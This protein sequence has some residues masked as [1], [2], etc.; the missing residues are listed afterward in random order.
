MSVLLQLTSK[1][2]LHA[3]PTHSLSGQFITMRMYVCYVG[4]AIMVNS[5]S[6]GMHVCMP[7]VN[8]S[9]ERQQC[10]LT[11]FIYASLTKEP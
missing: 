5:M 7:M 3:P 8:S 11:V 6:M 10:Q 9:E 1:C 2:T 4:Y